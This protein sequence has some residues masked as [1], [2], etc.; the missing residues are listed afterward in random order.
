MKGHTLSALLSGPVL[1]SSFAQAQQVQSGVVRWDIQKK[2]IPTEAPNRVN[3]LLRRAGSTYEERIKFEQTRGGYFAQ[4]EIGT[5]GQKVNLQL[6]TGSSDL[7]VPD[8]TASVCERGQ[9]DFGSCMCSAAP[10]RS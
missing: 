8:S 2:P 6:D 1:L 10:F 9:C 5:P 3:R 7:W 4:G